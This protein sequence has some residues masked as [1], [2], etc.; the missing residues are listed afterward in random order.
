MNLHVQRAIMGRAACDRGSVT[1]VFALATVVLLAVAGGA[2]DYSSALNTRTEMQHALD[3][4]VLAA[5]E[6]S[7]SSQAQDA[8]EAAY[9]YNTKHGSLSAVSL[10]VSGSDVIASATAE[11]D[12]S[13]SFLGLVG[14]NKLKIK[15]AA[16]AAA[17]RVVKSVRFMA[18]DGQG[19]WEK[20]VRLMVVRP[21][22]STPEEV[23]NVHYAVSA[24]EP[25][26]K[27]TVSANPSGWV[28][29]G[30]YTKAY[31]EF[32]IGP[33]KFEFDKFCSGC[34]TVL[35]SDDPDTSDRFT[36]DGEAVPKGTVL[37][38]FDFAKCGVKSEQTWEDGGGGQP[39]IDYSVETTCGTQSS[40]QSVRLVK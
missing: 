23:A 13:A 10:T 35:R 17:P 32:T 12:I 2:I 22:S 28:D 40:G 9:G 18:T 15:V 36:V 11:A 27:G 1:L 21:G 34:P 31:L 14:I 24:Q 6:E 7:D 19:W 8:A 16:S 26:P 3:A 29:L 25:P 5:V 39:D 30:A 38:I 20:Y 37:D 33:R 4:A